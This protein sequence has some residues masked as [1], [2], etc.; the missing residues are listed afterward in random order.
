[1][2]QIKG[3]NG[4]VRCE[5]EITDKSVYT[6]TLMED[7]YV[8]LSF[9]SDTLIGFAKKDY[10]ETEFGTFYI[11]D[12]DKPEMQSDGS[13]KYEQKFHAEWCFFGK[14]ILFYDRGIGYESS[15]KLT[16]RPEYFLDIVVSNL[17]RLGY[18]GYSFDV[19][20]SFDEM[21]VVEF[22]ATSII[23]A[24]TLIAEA[25]ET[26][27][28]IDS[29]VIH[30][31][32]CEIGTPIEL[33]E[34]NEV[35]KVSVNEGEDE[36]YM[37]RAYV[38]GST[39]NLPSDYRKSE[40]GTVVNGTTEVRL[41]LPSGTPYIDAW[42][43][44]SDEDV[45]E[46][47]IVL[48]DVY[49]RNI[50]TMS[51]ISTHEYTDTTENED[52]SKTY[53][54]WNA[55]RFTDADLANKGFKEEYRIDGEDL[56][57]IFQTGKLAGMDFVVN[58]NPDK[59]S[60][61]KSEAQIFEI[62]RNDDYGVNLPSD[63]FHPEVGDTYILYGY[64]TQFVYDA[65]VSEAE[66]ELLTKGTA[67]LADYSKDKS[68]YNITAN[69]IRCAGYTDDGTYRLVHHDA[70]EI[71]MTLGQS[72]TLK[73]PIIEGGSVTSRVRSFEKRLDNK[74]NATY[75]IGETSA[76][77]K[78][79]SLQDKVE[80]LTYQSKQYVSAMGNNIYVVKRYD[81]TEPSDT[82]VL[83]AIRSLKTFLRKDSPDSTDYLTQFLG[84]I[85]IGDYIASI[86]AGTGAAIDKSG[87]GEFESIRVRSYL[88]VMEL[89]INRL[90]ALEG[91]Q[92]LTEADTIESVDDLGDNCYGLHLRSKWDGYF[93]AQA[94]NNVLKGIVNT[95]AEG[96][97]TYY[98]SWMRVNSVNTANNYI[99]V[100]LYA[101]DETPAGKNFAPCEMM[102]IARWGNQ[103]DTT[104]QSCIYLS[105]TEGRIVRLTGVTK[106]IIDKSNYGATF[107]TL[108]EFIKSPDLPVIEGQDYVYARGLVVQD[109]IRMDYQGK[110][111][112][113]I[114]DRGEWS[115]AADYYCNDLNATTGVYETSDVW[116]MGCKWRCA[117]TGTKTA[118]AWNNTDWAMV[119]GNP[120][121]SVD[122]ADTDVIFDPDRFALTLT[123]IAT[124]Y[125]QDVTDDVLDADVEW[126]RYSED[127][128]GNPRTASDTTWALKRAGAGKSI[129]LTTADCDFN[130]YVPKTIRWTAKVT[131]RD[132]QGDEVGT[133]SV[134]YEY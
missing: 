54:K 89:I 20:G 37:T 9:K 50:G 60:E 128:N 64:N 34:G 81:K 134:S 61:E 107:G 21:K 68:V 75:V 18:T 127:A 56:R 109:I 6:S 13:Y 83:S 57:I 80:Q 12:I 66:Q 103:T 65:L 84:G 8:S 117:K 7:E 95:L 29:K 31:S 114:T 40:A 99:E 100:S 23:D 39:R 122:F 94:V 104:R 73:S 17:T 15:W 33:T 110:P 25:W 67:K 130:G 4:A 63:N 49:P 43:G 111:V 27:W 22:D 101:D 59:V 71:D 38:F 32:K 132:G 106:P 118:P 72:V 90:S 62:V 47:V 76:Y 2:I 120:A 86:Y 70:D 79:N 36:T 41:K 85:Y 115:S 19:D 55:Y 52:G 113:E 88:E 77:S 46:G 97:G 48:D 126:S 102:K 96:S 3:S 69:V 44:L 131:L 78:S 91:D 58:F 123:I 133:D 30:L 82:N 74:F 116:Y 45:V 98:T 11:M 35:S 121:F 10:I 108:P 1:M 26:D 92:L 87:A 125:N 5:V 53:T 93:T 42:T 105:S 16:Q 51:T 24:L 28:W 14:H 124:L 129:S 119:E 112:A